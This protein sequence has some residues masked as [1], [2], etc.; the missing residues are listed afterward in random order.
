MVNLDPKKLLELGGHFGHKVSRTNPKAKKY[1]YSAQSGISIIDLFKTIELAERAAKK[2]ESAGKD[3]KTLLVIASKKV[4]K[5]SVSKLCEELKVPYL[6]EKWVGGFFSNFEE[7]HKNIQ[8]ANDWIEE[9]KTGGWDS[10][11]KHE[12]VKLEKELHKVLKVYKGVLNLEKI[13]DS[14]LIVDVKKEKN[15]L[16]E[17]MKVQE[18]QR[19]QDIE[20][21]MSFAILDTNVNPDLVQYPVMI[22]DDTEQTIEYMFTY[23]IHAYIDGRKKYQA[24]EEKK[25]AVEEKKAKKIKEAQEI[26]EKKIHEKP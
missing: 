21:L 1:V 7:I 11:L 22:N 5:N 23:L 3:G 14:V 13:P 25:A 19:L 2:L 18:R 8:K 26:A 20:Q 24:S 15:A 6:C 4:A 17:S 10:M 12:R 9:Q 16:N